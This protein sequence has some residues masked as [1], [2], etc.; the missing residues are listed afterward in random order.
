MPQQMELRGRFAAG[1]CDANE[2][3]EKKF[4]FLLCDTL[5]SGRKDNSA[6]KLLAAV[7]PNPPVVETHKSTAPPWREVPYQLHITDDQVFDDLT[8]GELGAK[9]DR[10]APCAGPAAVCSVTLILDTQSASG[11][12]PERHQYWREKIAA[13]AGRWAKVT[14]DIKRF[15]FDA[16]GSSAGPPQR[17]VGAHLV[18]R[19]IEPL[20]EV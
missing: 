4:P 9:A 12:T 19:Y 1:L 10:R 11:K 5:P 3:D 8:T 15:D 2:G 17:R 14:V 6:K 20:F 13:N 7:P 18:L 16:K